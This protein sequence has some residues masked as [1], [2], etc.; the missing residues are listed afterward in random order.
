LPSDHLEGL[1]RF[2]RGAVNWLVDRTLDMAPRLPVR[3]RTTLRSHHSGLTDDEIADRLVT[4]AARATASVGA[5]GGALAAVEFAAPPMLLGAPLQLATETLAVVA[6][7]LKL[8]AELH[9]IYGVTVEGSAPDR[10][11]AYALAWARRRG[12]EGLGTAGLGRAARRELQN[13]MLRRLGRTSVTMTP[14]L[15]GAAAGSM[16]NARGTNRLGDRLRKDLRRRSARA[17]VSR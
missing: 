13:R 11:S 8:V 10:A 6:I 15:A 17:L 16:L 12:A 4:T 14:L 9:A 7:E 1:G 5:L 3:D 2:G